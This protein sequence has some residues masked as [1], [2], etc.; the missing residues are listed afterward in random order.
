M[1]VGKKKTVLWTAFSKP[2]FYEE[3]YLSGVWFIFRRHVAPGVYVSA[4]HVKKQ[5]GS[6]SEDQPLFLSKKGNVFV[7]HGAVCLIESYFTKVGIS[8]R[9]DNTLKMVIFSGQFPRIG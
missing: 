7:C 1:I 6:H 8:I 4:G 2:N 3:E 5:E 9:H